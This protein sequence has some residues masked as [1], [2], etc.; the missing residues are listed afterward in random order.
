MQQIIYQDINGRV[1]SILI[2][3]TQDEFIKDRQNFEA[4]QRLSKCKN[5]SKFINKNL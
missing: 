2:P 1:K 5:I 3:D 4:N